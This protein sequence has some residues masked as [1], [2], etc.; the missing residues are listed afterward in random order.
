MTVEFVRA[1]IGSATL[2]RNPDGSSVLTC[3]LCGKQG[4]PFVLYF[5]PADADMAAQVLA[6]HTIGTGQP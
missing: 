5:K 6:A 4:D 2:H 1:P 3:P